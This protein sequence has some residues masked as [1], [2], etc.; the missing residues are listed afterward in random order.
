MVDETLSK[1]PSLPLSALERIDRVC[2]DFEAAWKAGTVPQIEPFL[3][4]ATGQQRAELL[5][6]LLL[7]ELDYRRRNAETPD[8]IEYQR[9][10]PQDGELLEAV[11]AHSAERAARTI[12]SR[13]GEKVETKTEPTAQSWSLPKEFGRYRVLKA[14]GEGGMGSVF[15][16]HDTELDRRVAIKTPKFAGGKDL[17]FIERFYREARAA[18]RLQNR[19]ICPVYDVGEI[20]GVR[21]ISMAYIE[22]RPL[23]VYTRSARNQPE[24]SVVLVVRRLSLALQEAH[25]Q[26]VVH[27][28]LKPANIMIDA[29]REPVIMDFGLARQLD[30]HEDSRLTKSGMILGTPAYMSPEQ[31]S[32]QI[33]DVG[34]PSDIYSLGVILY[35]LLTGRVPFE[36]SM[37]A[38]LGQIMTQAPRRPSEFRADL[39]PRLE[40]ICLKMMAKRIKD[41]YASMQDVA[42]ALGDFLKGPADE[43]LDEE[44]GAGVMTANP[45]EN[46]QL[47]ELFATQYAQFL[48]LAEPARSVMPHNARLLRCGVDSGGRLWRWESQPARWRWSCLGF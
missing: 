2:L 16:A 46:Q 14:L 17:Q 45:D 37:A 32:S 8:I 10:F 25:S 20:D 9:R 5:K 42:D 22:G 38:V 24:R 6:E 19:H 30:K 12:T 21:Y 39:A 7:L 41:R 28:D 44:A 43:G 35:E 18:A 34:P 48:R 13:A 36:G 23:S 47:E 1:D 11:F 27:R 26:G 31:V 15:L 40:Q 29:K 3:G 4:D 33:G